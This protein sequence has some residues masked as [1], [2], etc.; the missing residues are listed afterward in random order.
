MRMTRLWVPATIA[1]I[2]AACASAPPVAPKAPAIPADQKMSWILQMEDQ[3]ILRVPAPPPPPAPVVPAGRKAPKA[4]PGPPPPPVVTPDLT[5]LI[6]DPEPRIRRRAAL[7]I[8]RVGLSEGA[9]P[10]LPLLTDPDGE[11]RQMAAFALGL[12]GDKSAVAALTAA[13]QDAE[14]RVRGRAAEALG[15]MGDA[16]SAALVG[17]MVAGYIQQ[18]AVAS[19]APDDE[20][21]PK[22]AEADAVRLGVFAL[23]RQKAWEPLAAAVLDSS[24]RPVSAWWPIAY[25]LQRIGDAR[26]VPALQQLLNGPGRYTRAFAARGLGALKH[27]ASVPALVALLQQSTSDPAMAF[28]AIHAIGQIGAP[29]GAA[30]ILAA[31]A[32]DKADLNVRLEAVAALTALKSREAL[33][34]VQDLLIDDSPVLRAAAVRAAAAIDPDGFLTLLSGLEPDPH[35][36]VRAAIADALATV[37]AEAAIGRLRP[38]LDD[39][40]K[41]VVPA[42]LDALV[43]LKAPG[44]DDL[45]LAALKNPDVGIRAAAARAIGR[46]KPAGGAAALRDAYRAWQDEARE[47]TLAALAQYGAAEAADTLK[48]A[49]A[50]KDWSIRLRAGTLLHGLDPAFEAPQ[51]IRPAPGPPIAPYD[52]PDLVNPQVSPHA[53][54][55]T[56][57]GTIE[58]ELAVLDAPQTARNFIALARKGFYNGLQIHRVVPH[59][60]VQD[61]DPRGDGSGGPGYTIRDELNDKPYLRGVVG[62]ALSGPD[63]GGSQFFIAYSPQPHLDAKYT[64]FGRVVSGMEVADRIQPLDVIQR[65]RIWDGKELK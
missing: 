49:L 15:L 50:D 21:W 36:M 60:V 37:P 46:T 22:T 29:E 45:L 48:A 65:V 2:S 10:L 5:T 9:A 6:T 58:I 33:I 62:M 55:E 31:L 7:A 41:R 1:A 16:G 23:V 51:A 32:A 56:A 57:K 53:F 52:S 47:S 25:A 43:R 44:I 14:P 19:I 30:P 35:W 64:V 38:M 13:L 17:Q 61:G 39:Q 18:G 34:P 11:V 4:K 20:Q 59:F 26:A 28:T 12:L 40:D 27:A 8:G 63:T 24:G 54:I 42:V 3:R